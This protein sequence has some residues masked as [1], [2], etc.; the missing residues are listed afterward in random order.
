LSI[1]LVIIGLLIG[2]LLVGQSLV[3]SS[4]INSQIQQFQQLD[5]ATRNFKSK[6]KGLPGDNRLIYTNGCPGDGNGYLDSGSSGG[7]CDGLYLH[8]LFHS[9]NEFANFFWQIKSTGIA[10]LPITTNHAGGSVQPVVK[11]QL[12]QSKIDPKEGFIVIGSDALGGNFYR[13]VASPSG[14]IYQ[15][16]IGP[17]IAKNLDAKMDDGNAVTGNV[18]NSSV[19]NV[20]Y[21]TSK[22]DSRCN[23]TTTG[24][25]RNDA[26]ASGVNCRLMIRIMSDGSN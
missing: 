14:Y 2:G 1:A 23:N 17:D 9:M 24:V 12:L 22:G 4:K 16:N 26:A 6:F 19:F 3:D 18:F 8:D 15:S 7:I 25:Y 5:I 20:I 21:T 10:N 13:F 11:Q